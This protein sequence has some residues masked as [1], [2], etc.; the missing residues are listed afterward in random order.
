MPWVLASLFRLGAFIERLTTS[1]VRRWR[2]RPHSLRYG[3]DL[4]LSALEEAAQP[5]GTA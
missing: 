5:A 4:D 2:L 3:H 1:H